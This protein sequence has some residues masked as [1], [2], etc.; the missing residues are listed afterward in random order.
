MKL[1]LLTESEFNDYISSGKYVHE[2]ELFYSVDFDSLY[3]LSYINAPVVDDFI[4]I[5]VI[6][7]DLLISN[8]LIRYKTYES[9]KIYSKFEI[10]N[11]EKLIVLLVNE[12]SYNKYSGC[13]FEN[14]SIKNIHQTLKLPKI[15]NTRNIL[16]ST[17]LLEQFRKLGSGPVVSFTVLF[18]NTKYKMT[19]LIAIFTKNSSLILDDQGNGSYLPNKELIMVHLLNCMN[20]EGF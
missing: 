20:Y 4:Y 17:H 18:N 5:M 14:F 19:S 3:S 10:I 16:K 7:E 6:D 9:I 15:N 2:S 1:N 12:R 13:M 11:H 8:V